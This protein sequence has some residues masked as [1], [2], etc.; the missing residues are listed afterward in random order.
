MKRVSFVVEFTVSVPSWAFAI[1]EAMCSPS[2]RPCRLARTLPRKNGSNSLSIAAQVIASPLLATDSLKDR[3]RRLG[4]HDNRFVDR[5]VARRV[6]EKIGDQLPDTAPVAIHR[7]I[8]FELGCYH[9]PSDASR[10]SSPTWSSTGS[11]G[12]VA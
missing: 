4:V 2:P 1:C 9:P 11:S 10:N 8:D 3:P 7:T 12:F 6:P 5:S